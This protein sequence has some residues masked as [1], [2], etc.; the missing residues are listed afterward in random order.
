MFQKDLEQQAT[1][2]MSQI[3]TNNAYETRKKEFLYEINTSGKYHI[4]KEKMKKTIVRIVR[5]KFG[6]SEQI[7]GLKKDERDNFYSELYVYL[8]QQM[9]DT[10]LEMVRNERDELHLNVFVPVVQ[11]ER[12][13]DH[14]QDKYTSE[15]AEKRYLRLAYEEEY[16]KDRP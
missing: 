16:L 8:V 2:P 14:L 4:L 10:V 15:N 7:K 6:K 13:R 3:E 11:G 9:K 1:I 12:E 5:E